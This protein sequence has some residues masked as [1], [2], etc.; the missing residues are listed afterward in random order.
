MA[1]IPLPEN[2][3]DARDFP[4]PPGWGHIGRNLLGR[5]R[6]TFGVVRIM[7]PGLY[8]YTSYPGTPWKM[9]PEENTQFFIPL[10]NS[11]NLA[12]FGN[13]ATLASELQSQAK[14]GQSFEEPT[15][16]LFLLAGV[17]Q[18]LLEKLGQL[19][20]QG[21]RLRLLDPTNV[22]YWSDP[23]KASTGTIPQVAVWLPDVGFEYSGLPGSDRDT[24]DFLDGARRWTKTRSP[25]DFSR[26]WPQR[27]LWN[28]NQGL[29]LAEEKAGVARMLGWVMD[30]TIH[31][32]IPPHSND[33][34]AA[35]KFWNERP[36]SAWRELESVIGASAV[37]NGASPKKFYEGLWH[38]SAI[39]QHF[40]SARQVSDAPP[41]RVPWSLI[42]GLVLLA[43]L[44]LTSWQFREPITAWLQGPPPVEPFAVCPECTETASP[45]LF[46]H[47]S[48]LQTE[49]DKLNRFEQKLI[50]P[51][52][53][54]PEEELQAKTGLTKPATDE[55]QALVLADVK[56]YL[57]SLVVCCDLLAE[58]HG[59]L[60][61]SA[62]NERDKQCLF[63]VAAALEAHLYQVSDAIR[64]LASVDIGIAERNAIEPQLDQLAA[65][66]EKYITLS[67]RVRTSLDNVF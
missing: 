64:T 62:P 5:I 42:F 15:R 36:G 22:I 10:A 7:E 14:R 40:R 41:R 52:R 35:V 13:L 12:G 33:D 19:E 65:K 31:E 47:L 25:V 57:Q 51:D 2:I 27:T 50:T 60:G 38:N 9:N 53:R 21:V 39:A 54:F 30:G 45:D 23:D 63:G 32:E 1:S 37:R 28:V 48:G 8:E 58:A 66:L 67:P 29:S 18:K 55:T 59:G 56:E 20:K 24:P 17:T 11:T 44:C 43:G 46:S 61:E 6:N 3:Q 16:E 26:L 4:A 49:L 34:P